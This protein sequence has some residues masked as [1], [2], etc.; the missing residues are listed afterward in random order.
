[1]GSASTKWSLETDY[2]LTFLLIA[3]GGPRRAPLSTVVQF[4]LLWSRIHSHH[5][6]STS[7]SVSLKPF[8]DLFTSSSHGEKSTWHLLTTL[9]VLVSQSGT[10]D[11]VLRDGL[12][13]VLIERLRDSIQ[14]GANLLA[15]FHRSE[16]C[17]D[18]KA[19]LLH[20]VRALARQRAVMLSIMN[21]C[22]AG[23]SEDE[24]P[25]VLT[26]KLH[27]DSILQIIR[28]QWDEKEKLRASKSQNDNVSVFTELQAALALLGNM[29]FSSEAVA[30]HLASSAV[31][32]ELLKDMLESSSCGSGAACILTNV[33]IS[34][35]PICF[36]F[37]YLSFPLVGGIEVRRIM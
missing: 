10:R 21:N 1:M 5:H 24:I 13:D 28:R 31:D 37:S 19:A 23:L 2:R 20:S 6:D 8:L 35:S 15:E 36:L 22:I 27:V 9:T 14:N 18:R 34:E 30:R 32:F 17:D 29:S 26:E 12:L 16:E 4:D 25:A 3:D 33:R 7:S 11:L